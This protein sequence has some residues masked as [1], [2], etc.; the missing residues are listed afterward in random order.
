MEEM[1]IHTVFWLQNLKARDYLGDLG[2]DG[3]VIL[4]WILGE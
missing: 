3:T 1:R 4:E 2:V